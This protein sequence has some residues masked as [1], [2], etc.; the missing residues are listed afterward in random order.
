MS[1]CAFLPCRPGP[2][3]PPILG[4]DPVAFHSDPQAPG[5]WLYGLPGSGLWGMRSAGAPELATLPKAVSSD[6]PWR[7]WIFYGPPDRALAELS[8]SRPTGEAASLLHWQQQM[9]Q[10]VKA[11]RHGR[12]QVRL[13]NLARATPELEQQLQR[14]LPE[15]ELT[16]HRQRLAERSTLPEELLQVAARFLLQGHPGLLNAY[17]D[18]ESW[19]DHPSSGQERERWRQSLDPELM[20]Q[21]LRHL[22][23]E[24][25]SARARERAMVELE[26]DRRA[27]RDNGE[28]LEREVE[29]LER[30]LEFYV[31]E[32]LQLRPLVQRLEEQLLRARRC[33][34]DQSETEAIRP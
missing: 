11:K 23:A 26:Q 22:E 24:Q 20:L 15:L 1:A 30:E 31:A 14:E 29:Q 7:A 8:A 2:A 16:V 33:L 25:G 27:E 21:M 12:Q 3:N 18:L 6:Q 17:L 32:H 9:E 4:N 5:L 19:A 34:E 13:L 28:R 10:A